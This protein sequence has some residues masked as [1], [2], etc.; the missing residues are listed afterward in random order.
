V[1]RKKYFDWEQAFHF[2]RQN[3]DREGIWHGNV[4]SLG[5]EFDVS[6]QAADAVLDELRAKRLVRSSIPG[7]SS[8]RNG[9]RRTTPTKDGL[10]NGGI[11]AGLRIEPSSLW[12]A[13]GFIFESPA[14]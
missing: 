12:G 14:S 11:R 2:I 4:A 5:A 3:A 6:E 13:T 10:N 1:K 7:H 8:F 9:G